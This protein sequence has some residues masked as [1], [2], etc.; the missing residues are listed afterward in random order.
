VAAGLVAVI[1]AEGQVVA[2]EFNWLKA[3][4]AEFIIE[5]IQT[6][7]PTLE[8]RHT[9]S[10]CVRTNGT[11]IPTFHRVWSTEPL[12]VTYELGCGSRES[13]LFFDTAL[14]DDLSQRANA[15]RVGAEPKI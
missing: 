5:A 14:M 15:A 4:D 8:P 6:K 13:R 9:T 12:R 11:Q 2:V 1:V 3:A 7:Y 10:A